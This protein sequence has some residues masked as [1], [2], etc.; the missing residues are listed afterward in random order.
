MLYLRIAFVSC[1][2]IGIL[3]FIVF[4]FSPEYLVQEWEAREV[5]GRKHL[6]EGLSTTCICI[7][8][9]IRPPPVLVFVIL[10]MAS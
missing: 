9:C 4:V 5:M 7:C 1:N 10:T 2:C 6:L 3:T 8:D